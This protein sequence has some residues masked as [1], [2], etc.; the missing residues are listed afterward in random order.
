MQYINQFGWHSIM[1]CI[2]S[3]VPAVVM[4][5]AMG[6]LSILAV[7]GKNPL[8]KI[9]GAHYINKIRGI[10]VYVIRCN[11]WH[12]FIEKWEAFCY[13]LISRQMVQWNTWIA[14]VVQPVQARLEAAT[15][16]DQPKTLIR[17]GA[18]FDPILSRLWRKSD[19]KRLRIRSGCCRGGCS[20]VNQG[21]PKHNHNRSLPKMFC[22]WCH[23]KTAFDDTSDETSLCFLCVPLYRRALGVASG[24]TPKMKNEAR[25]MNSRMVVVVVGPSLSEGHLYGC[26]Y[27]DTSRSGFAVRPSKISSHWPVLGGCFGSFSFFSW[28]E[29]GKGRRCPVQ[30]GV[31]SCWSRVGEREEVIPSSAGGVGWG[32]CSK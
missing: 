21:R 16:V 3:D 11:I 12:R 20:G 9:A 19:R 17:C 25:E 30:Q 14:C 7:C 8:H 29:A 18:A 27:L 32:F 5:F 2:A 15:L 24:G 6:V 4:P 13:I 22:I 23:I 31:F 28:S 1:S 26:K 10:L